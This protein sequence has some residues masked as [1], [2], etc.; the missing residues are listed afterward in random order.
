ML[1]AALADDA[2][3]PSAAA[4]LERA[5]AGLAARRRHR[6]R[7]ATAAGAFVTV[8]IAGG[9]AAVGQRTE[10]PSHSQVDSIVLVSTPLKAA[11]YTFDLTPRGWSVQQQRATGVTIAPDNGS[12][13]RTPNDFQGKLVI[14]FDRNPLT[15]KQLEYD[16]R[17][18]WMVGDSGYTTMAMA[19]SA[20]EPKGVVRI[21]Y[22][23]GTG[24]SHTQMLR[25]LTSIHVGAS[26][27]PGAG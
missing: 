4:D 18:I 20:G 13:S 12:A 19:T 14:L 27:Q 11:P 10:A 25:F 26:A 6:F 17:Q 21:Q 16:G 1:E 23:N 2:P 22:P 15:G 3:M 9:I 5:R 7:A 8:A 24:W